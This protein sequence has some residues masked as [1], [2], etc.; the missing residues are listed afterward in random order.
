MNEFSRPD[1]S[2]GEML[3]IISN[4]NAQAIESKYGNFNFP[5]IP[6]DDALQNELMQA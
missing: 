3:H 1:R 4:K 6:E 2:R 5:A